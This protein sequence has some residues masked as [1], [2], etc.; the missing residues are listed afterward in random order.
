MSSKARHISPF[1]YPGGKSWLIPTVRK[2]LNGRHVE[3]F[4]EPF[5]GGGSVTLAVLS[6][7]LAEHATICE[8]D[9]NVAS[10]WQ[11]IVDDGENFAKTVASFEMT[12]EN[13]RD[14]LDNKSL[15]TNTRALATIV[16]NRVNHGGIIA[17]GAG[18]IKLGENKRGITSRWYPE[19]L[20][21]RIL[22]I[23]SMRDKL[24]VICGDGLDLLKP[25]GATFFVDPPYPVVGDRL[26]THSQVDHERLFKA[27][28]DIDDFMMTYNDI[29]LVR[30]LAKDSGFSVEKIS[31]NTGHNK[32]K[33]ELLIGKDLSW[34]L[35]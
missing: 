14:M 18:L 21:K 10:V 35:N 15:S 27:M 7:S 28:L 23:Y 30:K 16:K 2:W 24:T 13:I 5:V 26:Y 29:P 33:Y 20:K 12:T 31:M 22:E 1:R 17:D 32:S 19:T 25:T 6:E 3:E 8:I 11:A 9:P 4:V 34:L